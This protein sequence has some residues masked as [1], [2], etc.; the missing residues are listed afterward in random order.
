MR[1][2]EKTER[3]KTKTPGDK[4]LFIEEPASSAT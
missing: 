4:L 2:E 3:A 1:N